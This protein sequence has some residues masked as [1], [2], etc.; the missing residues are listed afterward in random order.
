MIHEEVCGVMQN[1]LSTKA[2]I[3]YFKEEGYKDWVGKIGGSQTELEC[4]MTLLKEIKKPP[5]LDLLESLLEYMTTSLTEYRESTVN[6]FTKLCSLVVD[7]EKLHHV[8]FT[9]IMKLID[10]E[11]SEVCVKAITMLGH[12]NSLLSQFSEKIRI[13]L[14]KML[15]EKNKNENSAIRESA[16]TVLSDLYDILFNTEEEV[17]SAG[18]SLYTDLVNALISFDN[19]SKWDYVVAVFRVLD[20]LRQHHSFDWQEIFSFDLLPKYA[21]ENTRYLNDIPSACPGLRVVF[22]QFFLD[23]LKKGDY[24]NLYDLADDTFAEWRPKLLETFLELCKDEQKLVVDLSSGGELRKI[25][26]FIAGYSTHV[27]RQYPVYVLQFAELIKKTLSEL[28][29]LGTVFVLEILTAM[30]RL[31]ESPELLLFVRNYVLKFIEEHGQT[32]ED[33]NEIAGHLEVLYGSSD[34]ALMHS[35]LPRGDEDIF[36]FQSLT[37]LSSSDKVCFSLGH[38]FSYILDSFTF[39]RANFGVLTATTN[40]FMRDFD[41]FDY[42][43]I[44]SK[45]MENYIAHLKVWL[46]T[47]DLKSPTEESLNECFAFFSIAHLSGDVSCQVLRDQSQGCYYL[48]L[49]VGKEYTEMVITS[50]QAQF[51]TTAIP[52]I[53]Q[54]TEQMRSCFD[55]DSQQT[56]LTLPALESSVPQ[57]DSTT[58]EEVRPA[59]PVDTILHVALFQARNHS[60]YGSQGSVQDNSGDDNVDELVAVKSRGCCTLL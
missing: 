49:Y 47:H 59:T 29:C 27:T 35:L 15:I 33:I 8:F 60:P 4:Y 31:I 57:E 1:R 37:R 46:N 52:L 40:F 43:P 55:A 41:F 3:G 25:F 24:D 17:Y 34:S 26:E 20:Q 9:K 42:S 54:R 58:T 39:E 50:R 22:F 48:N 7:P 11:S 6:D 51:L 28:S 2:D 21:R 53:I 14:L 56:L 10:S 23:K 18:E 5:S 19:E 32:A 45:A 13:A 36:L 38:S 16:L 44:V 30:A 12:I